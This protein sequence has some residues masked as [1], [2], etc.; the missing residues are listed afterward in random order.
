MTTD[1]I[2]Q[3]V[4][5]AP[6]PVAED[7]DAADNV[8]RA[9][10]PHE[11]G[12]V[13]H[14]A[15]EN[16]APIAEQNRAHAPRV[17]SLLKRAG[18]RMEVLNST[19]AAT[20]A[21]EIPRPRLFKAGYLIYG[22]VRDAALACDKASAE[23]GRIPARE[24]GRT[25][26]D[27]AVFAALKNFTQA[28]QTFALQ[29]DKFA[30]KTGFEHHCIQTLIQG[31]NNRAAEAI[32]L[33]A[34]LQLHAVAPEHRSDS[35]NNLLQ[36]LQSGAVHVN[37]EATVRENLLGIG[38]RM[39]G[40]HFDAT[41][42]GAIADLA[43]RLDALENNQQTLDLAAFRRETQA[44]RTQVDE[45]RTAL[46]E[47]QDRGTLL[48]DRGLQESLVTVL[49]GITARLDAMAARSTEDVV[50][51]IHA[52]M[53]RFDTDSLATLD[54][55]LP[56]KASRFIQSLCT[57]LNE[58]ARAVDQTAADVAAR[59]IDSGELVQRLCWAST[60]LNEALAN[61]GLRLAALMDRAIKDP[62]L[63]T[64]DLQSRLQKLLEQ[65]VSMSEAEDFRA[66]LK[67]L[68]AM[69]H[70]S[71]KALEQLTTSHLFAQPS[72]VTAE[73]NELRNMYD[74]LESGQVNLPQKALSAAFEHHIDMATLLG[75]SLRGIAPDQLEL[76]A[77]D[78]VLVDS[79]KL[80]QGAANEVHLCTFRDEDGSERQLVF[81]AEVAARHGLAHLTAHNVGYADE[82]RVMQ[83]NVAATR[84]AD[85]IGCGDTVARASIGTHAGQIGLFMERA[86]G[87]TARSLNGDGIK[88]IVQQA[89]KAGT[90]DRLRGN[91]MRELC[92]LEWA[93]ALAGQVDRH[94]DN[95]LVD[96]DPKTGAVKVTGIDNDAA[97][98]ERRIGLTRYSLKG[99]TVEGTGNAGM[100]RGEIDA[101]GL[102]ATQVVRVRRL[103][104]LNQ[105]SKPT[106]IDRDTFEKLMAID[107]KA[108]ED[109]LRPCLSPAALRAAMLRLTDA[110]EHA[111]HL[112]A[113]NRVVEVDEWASEE[114]R[115][116]MTADRV[117]L[118]GKNR[119][120]VRQAESM[121]NGFF[122]RDFLDYF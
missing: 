63:K 82:T 76:Q 97:F 112:Q 32:N 90:V 110:Q 53:P 2:F 5:S 51:G 15:M 38:T 4:K 39:H 84:A 88:A 57:G 91:L 16:R 29:L 46:A 54:H 52:L 71:I 80:G 36:S 79:R 119:S 33:A 98:G 30:D 22:R 113:Q 86:R 92:R 104:G 89:K 10:T 31:A 37:D 102:T 122:I 121:R 120:V 117:S 61:R 3:S 24:F 115:K 1:V 49:D 58:Y 70:P 27:K 48:R 14:E 17:E 116:Q 43:G 118:S 69:G 34:M 13:R 94:K 55:S 101:E 11:A 18:V 111:L 64:E 99:L 20:L 75:S 105:F 65:A 26:M 83:I 41:L 59:R 96:L 95:Y 28:Q 42:R 66:H 67:T 60:A 78:A 81:K 107:R 68:A 8:A 100:D 109:S 47:V 7:V 35:D 12:E 85:A 108:Y 72:L 40:A 50:A 45:Y 56:R 103:F 77:G 106:R 9:Q 87:V 114:L 44:L 73:L 93:D 74:R 6:L 21:R 25:P 62:N 23:L 19:L